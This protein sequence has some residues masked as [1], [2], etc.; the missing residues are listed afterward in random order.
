LLFGC[1]TAMLGILVAAIA[2]SVLL[3]GGYGPF[4][5]ALALGSRAGKSGNGSTGSRLPAHFS[6]R[7]QAMGGGGR[8]QSTRARDYD[9]ELPRRGTGGLWQGSQ[10]YED[11]TASQ[12]WQ[13]RGNRPPPSNPRTAPRTAPRTRGRSRANW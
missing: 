7:I 12:V 8:D 13:A 4:L 9:D 2:L 3:R 11:Y 10:N 5:R 6:G 1:F